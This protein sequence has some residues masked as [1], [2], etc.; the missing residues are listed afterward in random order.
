[1][2]EARGSDFGSPGGTKNET[3]N[4]TKTSNVCRRSERERATVGRKGGR[5]VVVPAILASGHRAERGK[6]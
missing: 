5:V 6:N 2:R 4:E 1:M 3:K